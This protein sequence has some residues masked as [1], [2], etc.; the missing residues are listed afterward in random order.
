MTRI[1]KFKLVSYFES[2]ALIV[3]KVLHIFSLALT[4]LQW[5]LFR[6]GG[7]VAGTIQ[8]RW[9]PGWI[10]Y[11]VYKIVLPSVPIK[12]LS[13]LTI[14]SLKFYTFHWLNEWE[15]WRESYKKVCLQMRFQ[16]IDTNCF[17]NLILK[18]I[19]FHYAI[20]LHHTLLNNLLLLFLLLF[21]I[22]NISL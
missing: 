16:N 13:R 5:K 9:S 14:D 8:W 15:E 12:I 21:N 11:C 2:S 4:M 19:I 7:G 17:I 20:H 10:L 3:L 1:K 22:I 18:H 6:S